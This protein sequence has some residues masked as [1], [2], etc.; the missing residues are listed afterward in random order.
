MK[1]PIFESYCDNTTK[2]SALKFS[3]G[4]IDVYYSYQTPVAFRVDG[5]LTVRRN[6]WGPTTRKHLNAIDGGDKASRV[7]VAEFECALAAALE[8][9]PLTVAEV[10]TNSPELIE[11][12]RGDRP[13]PLADPLAEF[14]REVL[15]IIREIFHEEE[16]VY[17]PLYDGLARDGFRQVAG[18]ARERGLFV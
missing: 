13:D 11:R 18:L 17:S 15:D 1:L 8:P 6:E 12:M 10:S 4:R 3:L 14:G 9:Q 7:G 5:R 16:R 2:G